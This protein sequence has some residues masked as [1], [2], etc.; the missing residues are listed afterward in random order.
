VICIYLL[1]LA[2]LLCGSASV[3]AQSMQAA[4]QKKETLYIAIKYR[5]RSHE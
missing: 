2:A 3:V 4:G 1:G 5:W